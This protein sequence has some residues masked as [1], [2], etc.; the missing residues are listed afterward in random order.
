MPQHLHS[1][2]VV[3][4]EQRVAVDA[5]DLGLAKQAQAEGRA[6]KR[7]GVDLVVALGNHGKLAG[8][9]RDFREGEAV[10]DGAMPGVVS[11]QAGDGPRNPLGVGAV[12]CRIGRVEEVGSGRRAAFVRNLEREGLGQRADQQPTLPVFDF[13]LLCVGAQDLDGG[14]IAQAA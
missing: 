6:H 14:V 10:A 11:A 2:G 5:L 7:P 3:P 9:G 4:G 1:R 8:F 12:L 13:A